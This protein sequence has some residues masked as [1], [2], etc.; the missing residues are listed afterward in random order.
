MAIKIK[1]EIFLFNLKLCIKPQFDCAWPFD[2]GVAEVS[3]DCKAQPEGEHSSWVSDHWFYIDK[4]GKKVEIP[5]TI[6]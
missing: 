5:E 1:K 6:N 2:N 4:T 3:T